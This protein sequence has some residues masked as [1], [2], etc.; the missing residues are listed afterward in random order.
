MNITEQIQV[1][2]L[3]EDLEDLIT[4]TAMTL[5]DQ[6][7]EHQQEDVNEKDVDEYYRA[8]WEEASSV[9]HKSVQQQIAWLREHGWAEE[10]ILQELVGPGEEE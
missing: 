6:C 7:L 3:Q 1:Y 10:D 8:A 2:R 4:D 5:A 9:H